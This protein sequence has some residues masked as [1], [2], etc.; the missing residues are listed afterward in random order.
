MKE[1]QTIEIGHLP[2]QA[3]PPQQQQAEVTTCYQS[4]VML[5]PSKGAPMM[6][7]GSTTSPASWDLKAGAVGPVSGSTT[8]VSDSEDGGLQRDYSVTC[9]SSTVSGSSSSLNILA[10]SGQ[11]AGSVSGPP[12]PLLDSLCHKGSG[13]TIITTT[14]GSGSSTGRTMRTHSNGG[15]I[16]SVANC[17]APTTLSLEHEG[18]R[19]DDEKG[20]RD[21][22]ATS[23][24]WANDRRPDYDA[25]G[26][27][28][29]RASSLAAAATFPER[30]HHRNDWGSGDLLQQHHHHPGRPHQHNHDFLYTP[31]VASRLAEVAAALN[32]L[33]CETIEADTPQGMSLLLGNAANAFH[34]NGPACRAQPSAGRDETA[35]GGKWDDVVERRAV[36]QQEQHGGGCGRSNCP[37][38][39]DTEEVRRVIA[40]LNEKLCRAGG[41]QTA[42]REG[43]AFGSQRRDEEGGSISLEEASEAAQLALEL[44]R[45]G[46]GN[47]RPQLLPAQQPS[48][49]TDV[50]AFTRPTQSPRLRSQVHE[51]D[52]IGDDLGQSTIHEAW[53]GGRND[54]TYGGAAGRPFGGASAAAFDGD[55]YSASAARVKFPPGMSRQDPYRQQQDDHS[56]REGRGGDCH[57]RR[58]FEPT[59]PVGDALN[60]FAP[61]IGPSPRH[62]AVDPFGGGRAVAVPRGGGSSSRVGSGDPSGYPFTSSS[63]A[64]ATAAAAVTHPH[65]ADRLWS[66]A[67]L[68]TRSSLDCGAAPNLTET[69]KLSSDNLDRRLYEFAKFVEASGADEKAETEDWSSL[70]LRGLA[71]SLDA[72]AAQGASGRGNEK[73][74]EL[75]ETGPPHWLDCFP[76]ELTSTASAVPASTTT[77]T[78]AA[79]ARGVSSGGFDE[80]QYQRRRMSEGGCLDYPSPLPAASYAAGNYGPLRTSSRCIDAHNSRGSEDSLRQPPWECATTMTTTNDSTNMFSGPVA[81][82]S[83]DLLWGCAGGS[84]SSSATPKAAGR[85]RPYTTRSFPGEGLFQGLEAPSPYHR[86]S[87]GAETTSSIHLQRPRGNKSLPEWF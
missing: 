43:E 8:A 66:S 31:V 14:T 40:A 47:R 60:N 80:P 70:Y 51:E 83:M 27:F 53:S 85:L 64:A 82:T 4:A 13:A 21:D 62:L 11:N 2:Q 77:P 74:R 50:S 75:A 36:A 34:L 7:T 63:S 10:P 38:L 48:S 1:N 28:E 5:T 26:H 9:C 61:A 25:C 72:A 87:S 86:V 22:V 71:G 42:E 69:S 45:L 55:Y 52:R 54:C 30:D 24:S 39:C 44:L 15:L 67:P 33:E 23:S 56:A 19:T 12:S 58:P 73:P 17:L 6:N 84:A 16:S 32:F 57:H 76:P 78:A 79:A 68:L 37:S 41:L 46:G 20:C 49:G 65:P 35:V 29:G 59:L 18:E 3:L 81:P